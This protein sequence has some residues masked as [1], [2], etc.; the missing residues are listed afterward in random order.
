[1]KKLIK[2]TALLIAVITVLS[3]NTES[4][5]EDVDN[6]N[7]E[8]DNSTF[9][10]ANKISICHT[11]SNGKSKIL[12]ISINA[13]PEHKAHGDVRLDD[14]DSDGFVP[15]NNCDFGNQGDCDDTISNINP[16]IIGSCDDNVDTDGDGVLDFEDDCPNE[17]GFPALNGCPDADGDG[18]S[19]ANDNCP[20]EAGPASNN[21]CPDF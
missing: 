11:S 3:C 12:N 4:L 15:D 6:Q 14:Q 21:G 8:Q 10:K 16:G 19:D 5:I 1:M 20:T 2:K 9:K 7:I 13:W 17:F 18:I